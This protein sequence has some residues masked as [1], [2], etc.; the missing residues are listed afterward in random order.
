MAPFLFEQIQS[1]VLDSSDNPQIDIQNGQLL[2]TAERA[3][4]RIMITAPI[5]HLM[6]TATTTVVKTP[7][8]TKQVKRAP[9][10]RRLPAT[11]SRVGSKN[12]LAKLN[13]EKV[14]EIRQIINDTNLTKTYSS[15]IALYTDVG[16]S[17]GVSHWT[18]KNIAENNSWKH[19]D[20]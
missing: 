19:V 17:Y 5:G 20:A 9:I 15:R 13:E 2:L 7:R 4:A 10:K 3:D 14:R 11:D 6:P 12:R 18:I 8:Q 1:L 16:R